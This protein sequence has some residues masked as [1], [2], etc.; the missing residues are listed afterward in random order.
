MFV[1]KTCIFAFILR[2]EKIRILIAMTTSHRNTCLFLTVVKKFLWSKNA[3]SG[4]TTWISNTSCIDFW[5]CT[6]E[7]FSEILSIIKLIRRAICA[8]AYDLHTDFTA[9]TQN[10]CQQNEKIVC[11]FRLHVELKFMITTQHTKF[12]WTE[13]IPEIAGTFI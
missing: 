12:K 1:F 8:G 9:N 13:I 10:N 6:F 3:I 5:F 7:K 2:N 4:Q 11:I